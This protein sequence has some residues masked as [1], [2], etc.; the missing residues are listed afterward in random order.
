[1]AQN[2]SMSSWFWVSGLN[3]LENSNCC[4]NGIINSDPTSLGLAE[5]NHKPFKQ[6]PN[7]VKAVGRPTSIGAVHPPGKLLQP[8]GPGASPCPPPPQSQGLTR[9]TP[10]L[11]QRSCPWTRCWSYSSSSSCSCSFSFFALDPILFLFVVLFL[12]LLL[13]CSW[14]CYGCC[15]C[16]CS[17]TCSCPYSGSVP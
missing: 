2:T 11:G 17:H 3:L 6:K 14:S 10:R 16:S 15:S 1:M 9:Q 4:C 8:G 5:F 13:S 12:F 7:I